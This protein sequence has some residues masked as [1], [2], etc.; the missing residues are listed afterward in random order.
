MRVLIA[1]DSA[2]IRK[3]LTDLFESGRGFEVVGTARNGADA[4]TKV[5]EL[6]P[7][8]VTMDVEMPEMNGLSALRKIRAE[9]GRGKPAVLMCSTLTQSGSDI[10]LESLR[11]GAADVIAKENLGLGEEN[12]MFRNELLLK[13]R[14]IGMQA[15]RASQPA[16]SATAPIT[17]TQTPKFVAGDVRTAGIDA[18]VIGSSTGG[19]P[20]LETIAESLQSVP[21]R[22]IMI[23]Q[24]MPSLF[25]KSLAKRMDEISPARVKLA[26]DGESPE[27][28]TVYIAEGGFHLRLAQ[29]RGRV[30]FEVS[31]EPADALY[32]PSVNE[33][34]A[35]A[36]TVYGKKV[37]GVMLTGM[38]DDGLLG[39]RKMHAS[40][41]QIVA[42]SEDSCVV[43]G[44]PRAVV[45][46]G[47]ASD[48]TGIDELCGYIN[49]ASGC[50]STSK[51]GTESPMRRSA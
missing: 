30:V 3:M 8:I 34:F 42:Q 16:L 2:F 41:A 10:A 9:H 1:D 44:M 33:L 21:T 50:R 14:A 26:E 38:G 17:A 32:K 29:R 13:V 11:A 6:N 12:S 48:A 47:I 45:E 35:S 15:M 31:G 25:T 19:P 37:M 7:D 28:G 4:V 27:A 51:A 40:G 23:A 39:A 46:A 36:S 49:Q 43:Y 24:H 20:V 18:V 5:R 22:P